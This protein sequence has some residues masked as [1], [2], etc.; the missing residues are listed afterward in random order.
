MA[1]NKVYFNHKQLEYLQTIRPF[2]VAV[3]GRGT[4]KGVLLSA[5][6]RIRMAEMPRARFFLSSSTYGQLLTKTLPPMFSKWE[7]LGLFRDMPG[8]PGHYVV[9]IKP[10][11]SWPTP[12]SK[13]EQYDNLITFC[14]GYT[15]ELISLDR[16]NTQ[17]GGSFDGGDIDEAAFVPHQHFQDVMVPSIRG[18]IH[19]FTS[20]RHQGVN[21]VTSMP[22]DPRGD[23]ILEYE[24]KAMASPEVYFYS[25][26]TS[27]DNIHVLGERTLKMWETE[28]DYL[29]YQMEVMN[30]RLLRANDA[31]YHRYEAAKHNYTPAYNY[32]D[33]DEGVEV[34][35]FK[36]Y[37]AKALLDI[38]FD[39]GGNFNCAIVFQ[40]DQELERAIH[41]FNVKRGKSVLDLVDDICAYYQEHQFKMV[42]VWGEPRGYDQRATGDQVFQLVLDRFKDHAWRA[43]L[44]VRHAYSRKHGERHTWM[45]EILSEINIKLPRLR[46]NDQ[47]CKDL[48]I[49]L[50]LAEIRPDFTKNKSRE[51][52]SNYPQEHATHYTDALDYYFV[53]KYDRIMSGGGG[54]GMYLIR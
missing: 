46:I 15:I 42:R 49:A 45:N 53:Q 13:P 11:K 21:I 5:E 37:N 29:T 44:K 25:E 17:R 31:F 32:T 22:R 10:P 43:E 48:I 38:T 27:W 1:A 28:L 8:R 50:Q 30:R 34:G 20:P 3:W 41:T 54:R 14:N 4:G 33:G 36:D 35:G 39:F 12:Y 52:D 6:H 16:P 51:R 7:E 19:K 40:K 18:N 2:K 26:A 9:G 23:W 24:Q 47:T